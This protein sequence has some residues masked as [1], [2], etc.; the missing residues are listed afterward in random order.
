MFDTVLVIMPYRVILND[1]QRAEGSRRSC[2]EEIPRRF[3]LSE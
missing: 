3:A 1:R 2:Y